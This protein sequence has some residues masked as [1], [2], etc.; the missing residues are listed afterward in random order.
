MK[1][2]G[3]WLD[4]MRYS[5]DFK[6]G[7]VAVVDAEDIEAIQADARAQGRREGL[8]ENRGALLHLEAG[9]EHIIDDDECEQCKD[10]FGQARFLAD[11][12]RKLLE[13]K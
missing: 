3:F 9:L 6:P 7:M 4:A 2:A 8:E 5:K 13:A 1:T 12:I 11:Y 10:N